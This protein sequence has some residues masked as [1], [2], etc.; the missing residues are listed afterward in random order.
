MVFRIYKQFIFIIRLKDVIVSVFS[1]VCFII[2]LF[3]RCIVLFHCSHPLFWGDF[4]FDLFKFSSKWGLDDKESFKMGTFQEKLDT[5]KVLT[6]LL[7]FPRFIVIIFRL[8]SCYVK[9]RFFGKFLISK[10][11]S[12]MAFSLSKITMKFII[13][14]SSKR[15]SHWQTQNIRI[16]YLSNLVYS[17]SQCALFLS[18]NYSN[19]YLFWSGSWILWFCSGEWRLQTSWRSDGWSW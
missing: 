1:F 17:K 11:T 10:K 13:L 16:K 5:W 2:S 6:F 14:L 18:W 8:L 15:V 9:G 4:T 7:I 12:K 3:Y 19:P